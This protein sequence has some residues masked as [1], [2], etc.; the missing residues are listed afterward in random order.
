MVTPTSLV[1]MSTTEG[2]M[3][4]SFLLM[5][6]PPFPKSAGLTEGETTSSRDGGLYLP[7]FSLMIRF[8]LE[9]R[10]RA[11]RWTFTMLEMVQTS[12]RFTTRTP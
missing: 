3:G 12:A 8:S 1:A 4:W 6:E 9:T 11:E 10:T 5:M 2:Q 7:P